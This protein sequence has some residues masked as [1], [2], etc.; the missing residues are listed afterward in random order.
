VGR[1]ILLGTGDS[2]SWERA[3]LSLAIPLEGGEVALIGT[4]SGAVL[5]GSLRPQIFR[6][7]TCVTC[8]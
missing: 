6:S 4:S 5:L 3:Q 7:K 2:L 8:L 1:V